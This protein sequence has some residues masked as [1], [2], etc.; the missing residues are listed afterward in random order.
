TDA[1][2]RKHLGE[3]VNREKEM[4]KPRRPLVPPVPSPFTGVLYSANGANRRRRKLSVRAFS[5]NIVKRPGEFEGALVRA[6]RA[7]TRD[8]KKSAQPK[9]RLAND[10]WDVSCA[11][12]KTRA[13]AS[14][15][16]SVLLFACVTLRTCAT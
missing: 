4:R 3:R 1:C 2:Y 12:T 7:S 9:K 5:V 10:A 13:N 8:E 6:S 16:R 11:R 15:A 14:N